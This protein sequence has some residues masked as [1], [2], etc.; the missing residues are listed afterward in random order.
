MRLSSIAIISATF[1]A[2]AALSVIGAG[3]AVNTVEDQSEL[4]VRRALDAQRMHWAEVE[5]NGLQVF[6]TGEAPSEAVRFNALSTAGT[7]VDAARVIDQMT[8]EDSADLLAPTFSVEILRN[9]SGISL[10][11]LVP[12]STDRASLLKIIRPMAAEG[13]ATDLLE[14]A[15]Y[16]VPEAWGG[17]MEFALEALEFL[18][19]S[20]ISVT[21]GAVEI[22]AMA[23]SAESKRK[24]ESD[25]NRR[26]P[27]DVTL[28]LDITAPRPVITPFTLRFVRDEGGA[29]FDACSAQTD[30]ARDRILA[31]ATAAGLEG[32]A[33]CTVGMGVPSPHWAK[34]VEQSIGALAQIGQGSITF[35]DADITLIAEET[36][37]PA[38]F[39]QVI[40]ELENNLPEV[41]ALHSVLT[42]PVAKDIAGEAA[43]FTATLSPEGLVQLRGRLSD[44]TARTT[45]E[46]FAKARFGSK[47]IYNAARLD[48]G[49]PGR[50]DLRI[51]TALDGLSRLS[52]GLIVVTPDL[53]S[54][55]GKT[56]NTETN[57]EIARIFANQLAETDRFQIDV[58]YVE[59][60]DPIA[61]LPT[62]DE[63]EA[64][65]AEILKTR[66]INFEP[67]SDKP[68]A[69]A[70]AILDDVAN[71]LR[72]CEE[73]KMEIGGHTDSQ[74]REE[75]NQA[76]SQR[77]AQAVLNAL[78]QRQVLTASFSARGYGE[79]Q[80]IAD[81]DTEEGRDANRR[82]EIKLI[83]PEP[84][85]ESETTLESMEQPAQENAQQ[86]QVDATT[87]GGSDD[88]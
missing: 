48:E 32:N 49:L 63:C 57:A 42:K 65:V 14:I 67:G 10:I 21:A 60:L 75:M 26:T 1:G 71:V 43:E 35:S 41:F 83:R 20:K 16:P 88:G 81:N 3:F 73:L 80:P 40:G 38:T 50:W 5:A 44:E 37:N 62:P 28:T 82:I 11:G 45:V 22:R 74:G 31:A 69:E 56:G 9:D 55:S 29:R 52:N 53:I 2:A 85:Q 70:A 86:D 34:A 39:D 54:I 47:S 27:D 8:V 66:K 12:A 7:V 78:R 59:A 58:E 61:S 77:R 17:S 36:T 23:D 33:G 51:L 79:S 4:G 15:D 68:D 25:L 6:L 18:P 84:A 46:T 19:R 72:E 87:E 64:D 76:L 13:R 30:E 24:L